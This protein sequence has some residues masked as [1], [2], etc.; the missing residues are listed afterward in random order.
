[1]PIVRSRATGALGA[2][3][4]ESCVE[5][6]A[7]LARD[8]NRFVRISAIGGLLSIDNETAQQRASE[9]LSSLG[10]LGRLRYGRRIRRITREIERERR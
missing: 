7:L 3:G 9:A 10:A 4:D 1:V 5:P 8:P 2:L 6:L